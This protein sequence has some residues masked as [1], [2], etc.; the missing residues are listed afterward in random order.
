MERLQRAFAYSNNVQE[1]LQKHFA[2]HLLEC[3]DGVCVD[4]G[5]T[6]ENIMFLRIRFQLRQDSAIVVSFAAYEDPVS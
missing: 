1:F 5:L 6:E 2:T 4:Y 3:V